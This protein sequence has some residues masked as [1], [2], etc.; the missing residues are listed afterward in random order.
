M[1]I[2]EHSNCRRRWSAF[3]NIYEAVCVK[4]E[5]AQRSPPYT[6]SREIKRI[7]SRPSLLLRSQASKLSVDGLEIELCRR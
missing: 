1:R 5:C 7:S 3:F 4:S 6:V 2:R